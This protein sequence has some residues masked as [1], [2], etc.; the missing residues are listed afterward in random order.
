MSIWNAHVSVN[1][2]SISKANKWNFDRETKLK[3]FLRSIITD[4]DEFSFDLRKILSWVFYKK[5]NL[6]IKI[7]KLCDSII[8]AFFIDQMIDIMFFGHFIEK[9]TFDINNYSMKFNNLI[10]TIIYRPSRICQKNNNTKIWQI[11]LYLWD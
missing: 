1:V 11:H 9:Q 4:S 6:R 8:L 7:I 2:S 3:Y 10:C 5:K